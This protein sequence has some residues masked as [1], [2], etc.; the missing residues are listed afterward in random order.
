MGNKRG[1][2]ESSTL[3]AQRRPSPGFASCVQCC[4]KKRGQN[5]NS[6]PV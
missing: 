1:E 4:A 3:N 5:K 2:A 6:T